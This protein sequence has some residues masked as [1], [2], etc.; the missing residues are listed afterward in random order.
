MRD[1]LA[2]ILLQPKSDFNGDRLLL[3]YLFYIVV[4]C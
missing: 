2:R 1:S 4:N 3:I